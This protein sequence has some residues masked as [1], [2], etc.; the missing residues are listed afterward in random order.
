MI[1]NENAIAFVFGLTAGVAIYSV[2]RSIVDISSNTCSKSGR[3]TPSPKEQ[4]EQVHDALKELVVSRETLIRVTKQ[5]VLD[6]RRGLRSDGQTLKMIPSHVT[7]RPTGDEVGSFL[8]LDLG[9]TN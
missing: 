6:M 3:K 5:M 9:G 2:L 4:T 8:A 1:Q 7:K